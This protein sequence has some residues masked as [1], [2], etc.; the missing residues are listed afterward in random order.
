MVTYK[1]FVLPWLQRVLHR[2]YYYGCDLFSKIPVDR[3]RLACYG[4]KILPVAYGAMN[5][6]TCGGSRV[7]NESDKRKRK[8]AL[9]LQDAWADATQLGTIS[10]Y[11]FDPNLKLV[12]AGEDGPCR[13]WDDHQFETVHFGLRCKL[14]GL[15]SATMHAVSIYSVK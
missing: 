5:L 14:C 12:V 3:S 9:I 2:F 13:N 7:Q 6:L 8:I 15:F 10:E 1:L 4:A 11:V